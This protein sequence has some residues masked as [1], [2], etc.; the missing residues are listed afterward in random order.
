M[1]HFIKSTIHKTALLLTLAAASSGALAATA[2]VSIT[3]TADNDFLVVHSQGNAHSVVFRSQDGRNWKK[4]QSKTV[5]IDI[6]SIKECSIDII[7]WDDHSVKQGLAAV[8][9]GNGGEVHSGSSAMRA[10]STKVGN[11]R[12]WANN[13]YPNNSLVNTILNSLIPSSTHVHGV[14]G[15]A[16]PWGNHVS[17]MGAPTKW[18]WATD[19]LYGKPYTKNFTVYRTEC[20]SI[21][22]PVENTKKGLTWRKTE[23]DAVTGVVDVGCGHSNGQN[24]CNPYQGDTMCTTQLPILCKKEMNLPK[25]ASVTIPNKYHKWSGNIVGTTQPVAPATAGLNTLSAAND[26]CA[27]EFGAGWQ[28]AS[29]HDGWGWYFKA[30]GNVGSSVDTKR[31]W[32]NIRDQQNGNCWTQQ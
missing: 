14:V 21:I 7:A 29:H 19:S 13:N 12:N 17:G 1:K 20:S 2:Q 24:E 18:I 30:Y 5:K 22:K 25:P 28:V 6:K 15:S 3:A 4:A 32:V 31:Y 26:F 27:A 16:A 11:Q 8:L 23:V 10:Y 9:S